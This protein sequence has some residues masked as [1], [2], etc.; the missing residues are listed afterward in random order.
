M[1]LSDGLNVV[2]TSGPVPWN[3]VTELQKEGARDA[4]RFCSEQQRK[5]K[6]VDVKGF[7]AGMFSRSTRVE[8]VFACEP[9]G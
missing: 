4:T 3:N 7:P 5:V 8:T 6:V 2:S 9:A 1:P